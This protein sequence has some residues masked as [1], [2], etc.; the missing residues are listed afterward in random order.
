MFSAAPPRRYSRG[1]RRRLGYQYA[2]API[3]IKDCVTPASRARQPASSPATRSVLLV[4]P[5][6]ATCADMPVVRAPLQS[7][8]VIRVH[9]GATP[10]AYQNP[11]PLE[12]EAELRWATKLLAAS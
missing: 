12:R 1:K 3:D 10:T 11:A 4:R 7:P 8:H 9:P 5:P 6:S 2:A